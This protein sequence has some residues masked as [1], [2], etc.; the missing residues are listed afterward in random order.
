VTSVRS[1][2]DTANPAGGDTSVVTYASTVTTANTTIA[3]PAGNGTRR[4]SPS[5]RMRPASQNA[6]AANASTV[7]IV[8]PTAP[9]DRAPNNHSATP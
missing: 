8:T 1:A 3:R 9:L 6:P 7:A 5:A 2:P 4:N